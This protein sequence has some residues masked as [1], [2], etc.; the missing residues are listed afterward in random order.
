MKLP[1]LSF[2]FRLILVYCLIIGSLAWFMV[3]KAVD[4]LD[5]SVRQ[6]AEEV[7][8]DSANL[9]AQVI[10]QQVQDDK[11]NTQALRSLVSAYLSRTLK[12]EIYSISKSQPNLHVYI[13]DQTGQLL[14]DSSGQNE[15]GED[16]S[17]WRDVWL[18]LRGEYGARSTDADLAPVVIK[19]SIMYVAAAIRQENRIV[20]VVSV[21]KHVSDFD[22]FV[23]RAYKQFRNYSALLLLT[24]L[25]FGGLITWWLAHSIRKLVVYADALGAGVKA[26]PPKL[27][28]KEL[29]GLA[30]A[31]TDM[32]TELQDKAYVERYIHTLAHE[33]KSP[34]SGIKGAVE[35]LH[36][37]MSDARRARFVDNIGD[38]SERM[39]L[40]VERLLQLARVE[41][42]RQLENV[43]NFVLLP[44][45]ERLLAARSAAF[46]A[47][48]LSVVV[49]VPADMTMTGEALLIEQ[50]L[51]NLLDNA[52]D[53]SSAG[54]A[55][56]IQ[57]RSGSSQQIK[58]QDQGIGI[59]VEMQEK[60]FERFISTARPNTKKR[61]TGLG[62]SFVREVMVL[63]KGAV[64]IENTAPG[65]R[66]CL[67]WPVQV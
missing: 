6:A 1:K 15:V 17:Q 50:A 48:S 26:T 45:I 27:R 34:L 35:L 21:S 64:H 60:V 31:M 14:Y 41:K 8:I 28:E 22:G 61:S 5:S 53:F 13:T 65:L 59:P 18:T 36:E 56:E 11:I 62:L 4:V 3:S 43:Q 24:S 58:I 54:G 7:M 9:L 42:Q 2:S 49:C 66:V 63:H 57:T 37:P 44:M 30:Q 40:L 23:A 12:A 33:L 29:Q 16:F 55:V 10:E 19:D 47:K 52:I 32:Q 51:A 39:L 20:G 38:S 25:L 46:L 67:S